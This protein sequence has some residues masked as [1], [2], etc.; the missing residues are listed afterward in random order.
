[1]LVN[2]IYTF[3][4]TNFVS[5]VFC[6]FFSLYFCN[7]FIISFLLLILGLFVLPFLGLDMYHYVIYSKSLFFF[8]IWKFV[9][10]NFPLSTAFVVCHKFWYGVFLVSFVSRNVFNFLFDFISNPLFIQ[11]C[12]VHSPC[13]YIISVVV[14][15]STL[16]HCDH[17]RYRI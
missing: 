4:K 11:K 10:E 7:I 5:L 13:I 9:A 8:N 17:K 15:S 16:F 14:D 3:K 2:V 6:I 12:A 1:M